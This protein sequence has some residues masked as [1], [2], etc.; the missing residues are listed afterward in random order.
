MTDMKIAILDDYFDTL[1]TLDCFAK[2]DSHAAPGASVTRAERRGST[3]RA[4]VVVRPVLGVSF[5]RDDPYR[6]KRA[7]NLVFGTAVPGYL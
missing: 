7:G 4:I 5:G 1:R 2:L 6:S 3:A